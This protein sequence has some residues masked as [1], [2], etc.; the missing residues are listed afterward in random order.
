MRR[1]EYDV[2]NLTAALAL[3]REEFGR[4]APADMA[5]RAGVAA[6]RRGRLVVPFL[7]REYLLPV[8]DGDVIP[9]SKEILL[10]HYLTGA[11]G[12][13]PSGEK[14]SFKDLPDGFIYNE[15]FK[16]RVIRPLVSAFGGRPQQL[17]KAGTNIGGQPAPF[18]DAATEIPALPRLPV[19]FFIWVG[20]EEFPPDGGVLFDANITS[21][22][23]AED[24][25]MLAQMSVAALINKAGGT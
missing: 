25:V 21:Y 9:A 14:V 24:C 17:V 15:P 1:G 10:L 16:N 7:G 19:V 12:A 3:A 11:S 8:P 5:R 2:V 20:D 23:A 13:P 22:L 6:D 4:R 18:G